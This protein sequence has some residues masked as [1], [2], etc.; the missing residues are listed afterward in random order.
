MYTPSPHHTPH[1]PLIHKTI[2]KTT[3]SYNLLQ[4]LLAISLFV[5]IFVFHGISTKTIVSA[6]LLSSLLL[7]FSFFKR[8]TSFVLYF[9]T[10]ML[11]SLEVFIKIKYGDF[12]SGILDSILATNKTEACQM[13]WLNK[14]VTCFITILILT[15]SYFLSKKTICDKKIIAL[16]ILTF[17]ISSSIVVFD[18]VKYKKLYLRTSIEQHETFSNFISSI[19]Q[20]EKLI[21]KFKD[22]YPVVLGN[23]VY[24]IGS[25]SNTRYIQEFIRKQDEHKLKH[26][27]I[28]ELQLDKRVKNVIIIMSESSSS[29]FYSV[30]GYKKYNTNP[31]INLLK[32]DSEISVCRNIHSPSNITRTS[33]PLNLSFATPQKFYDLYTYKSVVN[34]SKEAGYKTIWL[35]TQNS[36]GLSGWGNT[37]EYISRSS[38]FLVSP[39]IKN[40]IFGTVVED[41]NLTIPLLNKAIKLTEG[42]YRFIVLHWVGNHAPYNLRYDFVDSDKYPEF[43]EYERSILKSDRLLYEVIKIFRELKEEY[44]LVFTSDH[45]EIPYDEGA[46]KEHGLTYGGY[47]QYE[48]PFL[49]SS[50]FNRDD[51]KSLENFRSEDGFFSGNFTKFVLLQ[52]IGYNL[53]FENLNKYKNP[54][55]ILHSDGN[56]YEYK[57]LPVR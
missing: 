7:S 21:T 17:I 46:G 6:V 2:C 53:K 13:L 3:R 19:E 52:K 45:G 54:D 18:F 5:V 44:F 47:G 26:E 38:E 32:D 9:F 42:E 35:A 37:Y 55:L 34:L 57:K 15:I 33:V 1:T 41:D 29:R 43:P 27:T 48:I 56:V 8:K 24:A 49:I 30:Y 20:R 14:E 28:G 12:S 4:F 11:V 36:G 23:I 40:D 25:L 10:L 22:S 50:S 16:T 39:D 31:K 51:C